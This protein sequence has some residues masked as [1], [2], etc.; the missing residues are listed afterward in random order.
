MFTS[1]RNKLM[2]ILSKGV[3]VLNGSIELYLS[4]ILIQLLSSLKSRKYS[5]N[6]TPTNQLLLIEIKK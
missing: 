2:D 3:A 1:K 6:K 4:I 5:N